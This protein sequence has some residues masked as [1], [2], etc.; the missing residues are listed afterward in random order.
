MNNI[1]KPIYRNKVEGEQLTYFYSVV[2]FSFFGIAIS[3]LHTLKSV[4]QWIRISDPENV[5][6]DPGKIQP[7]IKLRILNL[8]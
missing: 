5:H 3:L 6:M 4:F 2:S 7:V 8:Y 1:I